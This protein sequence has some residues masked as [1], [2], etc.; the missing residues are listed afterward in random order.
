MMRFLKTCAAM[1][2]LATT[3]VHA[4][5]N[6]V[7]VE[8]FTSQGCSSCPPADKLLHQ[9]AEKDGVI[10]LSL[11]VDYWDYI[12]WKDEFANPAHTTRQKG[13]ARVANRRSIYTPQM[14]IN[15]SDSVVG[16]KPMRVSDIVQKHGQKKATV[17][18]D[19]SRNGDKVTIGAQ[20]LGA[21]GDMVVHLVHYATE[22]QSK[23]T[24]GENAGH[25]ITY[26][27][28]VESWNMVG[29]WTGAEALLLSVETPKTQPVVVM[30]QRADHGEILAAGMLD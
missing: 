25:T 6:P 13:Y 12:G 3:P 19:L 22:K 2:L 4:Q 11:H 16:A 5:S 15:G 1:V 20:S 17:S 23:I 18:L 21:T 9:L 28:V 8:L 30:I 24:R 10:A 27:N 7:V 29:E 26:V 14:I